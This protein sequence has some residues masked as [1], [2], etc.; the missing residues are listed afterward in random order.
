MSDMSTFDN[1]ELLQQAL[2]ARRNAYAPYS[3]F[4]VGAVLVTAEGQCFSGCNIENAS[5]SLTVCAERSAIF[6]AVSAGFR[7]FRKIAI[8]GGMT[9]EDARTQSCPPCGACLQVLAEFCPP[10]FPVCVCGKTADGK[11]ITRKPILP[12]EEELER[13]TRSKSAKL[14]VFEKIES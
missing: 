11:V 13:N 10:E 14:R 9:E 5:Y 6:G 8:V 1:A 2:S 7:Q 4:Q 3:H 12:S